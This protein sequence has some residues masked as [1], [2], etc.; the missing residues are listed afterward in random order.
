MIS[1]VFFGS[2]FVSPFVSTFLSSLPLPSEPPN[3][4]ESPLKIP[5]PP[6]NFLR[7]DSPSPDPFP[8][9]FQGNK[10]EAATAKNPNANSPNI[11]YLFFYFGIDK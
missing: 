1:S 10:F 7:P 6:N 9:F 4:A 3:N 8:S 2:S 5:A 11:L